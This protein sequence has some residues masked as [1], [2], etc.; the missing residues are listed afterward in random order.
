VVTQVVPKEGRKRRREGGS[1]RHFR[2]R[3]NKK[4]KLRI[5]KKQDRKDLPDASLEKQKRGIKGG[6]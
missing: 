4:L 2:S 5:D 6:F 1:S 3:E